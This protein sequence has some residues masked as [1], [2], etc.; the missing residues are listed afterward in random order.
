LKQPKK[1][2]RS[3]AVQICNLT[4]AEV[5]LLIRALS[6]YGKD[7]ADNGADCSAAMQLISEFSHLVEAK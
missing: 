6:F 7:L 4:D 2:R 5:L 3:E 1:K